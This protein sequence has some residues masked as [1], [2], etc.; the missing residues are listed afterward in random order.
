M[1]VVA[2][3]LMHGLLQ[4]AWAVLLCGPVLVAS[5]A[6]TVFVVR[7][8]A[9]A[10]KGR[11]PEGAD[12]LFWDLFLGSCV[13]LPALLI[14]ALASPWAGLVLA[15]AATASGIASYRVSPGFLAWRAAQREQRQQLSAHQAARMQ[16]DELML[17][18][19]RYELDP[20]CNIDYPALTDVR[21]PETSALIKA[22]RTAD[23]LR[24]A[25]HKGYPDAVGSLAASLAAA[26]RAAGIPAALPVQQAG[27]G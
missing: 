3:S 15:G 13:A 16:H 10:P 21:L 8:R 1:P 24:T 27:R 4:G 25:T 14:P 18:W 22:M 11:A 23:Q 19:Q 9:L 2:E 5:V 17:R 20:A 6:A 12:Q 7:R 26:E